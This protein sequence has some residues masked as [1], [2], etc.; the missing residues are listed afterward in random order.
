M[1]ASFFEVDVWLSRQKGEQTQPSGKRRTA[2]GAGGRAGGTD[3]TGL[4]VTA[5]LARPVRDRRPNT[6]TGHAREHLRSTTIQR[7]RGKDGGNRRREEGRTAAP[8]RRLTRLAA[9]STGERSP[10]SDGNQASASIAAATS[11]GS[12]SARC[13]AWLIRDTSSC[14]AAIWPAGSPCSRA[15][16]SARS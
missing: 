9:R 7:A 4:P 1:L 15:V 6:P 16:P 14:R 2:R 5:W 11:D 12:S 10:G 13:R 8:E 3:C